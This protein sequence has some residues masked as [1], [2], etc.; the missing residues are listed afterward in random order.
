MLSGDVPAQ[1]KSQGLTIWPKGWKT[2][3]A[4]KKHWLCLCY[5]FSTK[6]LQ[7]SFTSDSSYYVD[8][9]RRLCPTLSC[10][11][12]KPEKL[13]SDP[14]G[15][16]SCK[17]VLFCDYRPHI[18]LKLLVPSLIRNYTSGSKISIQVLKLLQLKS[19][20]SQKMQVDIATCTNLT[21]PCAFWIAKP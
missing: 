21:W 7:T 20:I 4:T 10:L 14:S 15:H 13:R 9:I 1:S 5:S 17:W 18:P 16:T 12:Y 6:S 19:D 2:A 8:W 11:L 3:E